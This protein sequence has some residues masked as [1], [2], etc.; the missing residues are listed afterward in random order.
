MQGELEHKRVKAYYARTNKNDAVG[1][2]TQLERR[3]T[4]LLKISREQKEAAK[5]ADNIPPVA[6]IPQKRKRPQGRKP[7]Q[8][9]FPALD[10]AES[11]SLPYTPPEFHYHISQSRNFHFNLRHWLGENHGDPAV[12]V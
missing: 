5:K 9:T 1:Q 7:A 2:I 3:D 6:S 12:K 8:K 4:A 11:E 10:F